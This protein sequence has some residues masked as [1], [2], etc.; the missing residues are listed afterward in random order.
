M[1]SSIQSEAS[2]LLTLARWMAGE[3][4]N[5]KQ[6][7]ES[8]KDFAHIRVFFRPL[9]FEFFS[10]VGMYSEQVY[11]YDL[12]RPYRQGVHRLIEQGDRV[13][14]ENY[15]LSTPMF[16]AGAAREP[17]ILKTITPDVIQR[18]YNCSMV[19]DRRGDCFRG[20]VEGKEWLSDLS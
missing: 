13:Y 12:W 4:S 15:G 6:A 3:F 9:P 11:D 16:F 7:A 19:F 20:A 18:R 5:A 17:S 8:P 10:G 2:L 14:I 1:S